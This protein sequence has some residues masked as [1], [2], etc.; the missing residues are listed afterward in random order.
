MVK[1]DEGFPFIRKAKTLTETE[2]PKLAFINE[3]GKRGQTARP[4]IKDANESSA[5]QTTEAARKSV[6]RLAEF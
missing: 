1:A 4:F 2:M 3:F 6:R 5:A